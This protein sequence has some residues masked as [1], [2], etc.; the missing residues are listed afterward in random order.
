MT[1]TKKISVPSMRSIHQAITEIRYSDPHTSL[2]ERGLRRLVDSGEIDSIR[3]G[4]K[5]LVN[6]QTLNAYLSGTTDT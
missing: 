5:K 3:I 1:E 6:M 2:T 4:K